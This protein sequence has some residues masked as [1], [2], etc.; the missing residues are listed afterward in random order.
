MDYAFPSDGVIKVI[1]FVTI[2]LA[3]MELIIPAYRLAKLCLNKEKDYDDLEK[4][5]QANL[6]FVTDYDRAN[7]IT[8]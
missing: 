7:P 6:K 4:Y 8:Q 1:N 3:G 5:S 2:G